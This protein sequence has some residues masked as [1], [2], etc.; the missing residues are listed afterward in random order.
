VFTN[1]KKPYPT[2][3]NRTVEGALARLL[4]E[5]D[6]EFCYGTF[7]CVRVSG[8]GGD[9]GGFAVPEKEGYDRL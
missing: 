1:S 4:K 8:E 6:T 9:E 7:P 2:G 3:L 5:G